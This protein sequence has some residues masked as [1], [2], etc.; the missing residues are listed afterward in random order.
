[1][2]Y[3]VVAL[4]FISSMCAAYLVGSILGDMYKM[5]QIKFAIHENTLRGDKRL[6]FYGENA[7][8]STTEPIIQDEIL[9]HQLDGER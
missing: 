3:V 5:N 9:R 2:R 4:S 6:V 1:M 8:A 7:D